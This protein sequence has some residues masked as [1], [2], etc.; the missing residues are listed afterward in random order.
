VVEEVVAHSE[1]L[2]ETNTHVKSTPRK[3]YLDVEGIGTGT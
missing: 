1:A 2:G 3:S